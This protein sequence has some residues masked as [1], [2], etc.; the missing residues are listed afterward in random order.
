M[1][2]L[3]LFLFSLSLYS[4]PIYDP[5]CLTNSLNTACSQCIPYFYLKNNIC[6]KVPTGCDTYSETTGECI[7]CLKGFLLI[8]QKCE[9]PTSNFNKDSQTYSADGNDN[10]STSN[11][12][13][14]AG[15]QIIPKFTSVNSSV[16]ANNNHKLQNKD[17]IGFMFLST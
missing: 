1:K 17:N 7:T 9:G 12:K 11:I 10:L 16:F 14:T 8:N 15:S 4:Q 2:Y 13:Q 6:T 5:Y 3:L